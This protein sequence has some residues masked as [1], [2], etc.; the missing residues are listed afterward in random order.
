M[1]VKH[2]LNELMKKS[3]N[4]HQKKKNKDNALHQ[5]KKKK[6]S[7]CRMKKKDIMPCQ[8]GVKWSKLEKKEYKN[9][10][11]NNNL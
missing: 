2:S 4:V 11:R 8:K 1:S 10:K 7:R 5:K 9:R 3:K 6:K